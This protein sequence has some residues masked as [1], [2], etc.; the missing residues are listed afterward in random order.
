MSILT[1][2]H[3]PG[4]SPSIPFKPFFRQTCTRN[5]VAQTLLQS[6]VTMLRHVLPFST[7]AVYFLPKC[8]SRL[9][10]WCIGDVRADALIMEDL[11]R[12]TP[13]R[14]PAKKEH[15]RSDPCRT[16][17]ASSKLSPVKQSSCKAC[18]GCQ[19]TWPHLACRT[20]EVGQQSKSQQSIS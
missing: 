15:A 14:D 5:H 6:V 3:S 8:P 20:E 2:I 11:G 12:S 17:S 18:K 1:D 16:L 13:P 4:Q 10:S 19:A 7:Y 9:Q